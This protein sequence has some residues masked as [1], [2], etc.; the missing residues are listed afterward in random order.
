MKYLIILFTSILIVCGSSCETKE[1]Q[2]NRKNFYSWARGIKAG[3]NWNPPDGDNWRISIQS[4][5][6]EYTN[7][8]LD[9]VF[10]ASVFICVKDGEVVSVYRSPK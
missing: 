1:T 2:N 3:D 4:S 5:T 8:K 6:K 10:D 9:I 7:Y